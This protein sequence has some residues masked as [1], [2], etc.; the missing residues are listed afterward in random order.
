MQEL[1]VL[2]PVQ[3]CRSDR[4]GLQLKPGLQKLLLQLGEGLLKQLAQHLGYEE[5]PPNAD[6]QE[7]ATAVHLMV[8]LDPSLQEHEVLDRVKFR[9]EADEGGVEGMT[10][11]LALAMEDTMRQ[12]EKQKI[13]KGL[14]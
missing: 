14:E 1:S 8:N 11:E 3:G 6:D 12:Q 7:V 10:E 2:V 5:A 4:S 13:L 9:N